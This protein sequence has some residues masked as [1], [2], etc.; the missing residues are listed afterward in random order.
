[1]R[2]STLCGPLDP[3]GI[4]GFAAA[5]F[6]YNPAFPSETQPGSTSIYAGDAGQS[7]TPMQFGFW[8]FP[9]ESFEVVVSTVLTGA[10]AQNCNNYTLT[11]QIGKTASRVSSVGAAG[12][13]GASTATVAA[14]A[15]R[16]AGA[17][18]K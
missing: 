3:S 14:A 12:G 7:G 6:E 15:S 9:F 8:V 11:V 5:Y 13:A 1:V 18:D 4:N 10:A 17:V 2:L 16:R